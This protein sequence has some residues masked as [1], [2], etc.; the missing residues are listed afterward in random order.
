MPNQ[1]LQADGQKRP[2]LSGKSL[3]VTN[4]DRKESVVMHPPENPSL[5]RA[6][7]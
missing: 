7:W 6:C 5:L 2:R 1:P 4:A 3:G